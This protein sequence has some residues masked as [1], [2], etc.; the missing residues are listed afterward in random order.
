MIEVLISVIIIGCL[1]ALLTKFIEYVLGDPWQDRVNAKAIF[2]KL[3][4]WIAKGY[5]ES[6]MRPTKRNWF[7]AA[8]ACYYCLNVYVTAITSLI[9]LHGL[10]ISL[11]WVILCLPISHYLLSYIMD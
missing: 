11:L 1:C 5:E 9:A 7:M 3:G 4:L 8:G 2:G 6:E 10:E